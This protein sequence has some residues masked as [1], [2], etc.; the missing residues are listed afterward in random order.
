MRAFVQLRL[1]PP[2]L[3][4]APARTAR[5]EPLQLVGMALPVANGERELGI[6][7]TPLNVRI[8]ALTLTAINAAPTAILGEVLLIRWAPNTSGGQPNLGALHWWTRSRYAVR[9]K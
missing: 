5:E 3:H 1:S 2:L 9:I 4:Q 7:K 6:G 8:L